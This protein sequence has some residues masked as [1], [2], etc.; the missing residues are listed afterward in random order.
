[1][2]PGCAVIYSRFL[3]RPLVVE[4]M[5]AIGM[6]TSRLQAAPVLRFRAGPNRRSARGSE[7]ASAARANSRPVRCGTLTARAAQQLNAQPARL[8]GLTG[9]ARL[10]RAPYASR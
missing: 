9:K 1:L 8:L 6:V 3:C 4:Q 5:A 2:R 7:R 10:L